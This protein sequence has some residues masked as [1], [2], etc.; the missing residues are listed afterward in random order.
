MGVAVVGAI[1]PFT[2]SFA[3]AWSFGM[4]LVGATFV[5]L[6]MTAT[7]VVITL[8]SLKDLRASVASMDVDRATA[9]GRPGGSHLRYLYDPCPDISSG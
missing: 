8:T 4:D 5:G 3:I 7:A 6:T 2:V 1:V 9:V